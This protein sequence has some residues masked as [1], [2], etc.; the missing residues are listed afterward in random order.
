MSDHRN[1]PQAIADMIA[2]FGIVDLDPCSNAT[3]VIN[4]RFRI[5]DGVSGLESSWRGLVYVN[6]PWSNLLPWVRKAAEEAEQGAEILFLARTESATAWA[7]L[8]CETRDAHVDLRKRYSFPT[9]GQPPTTDTRPTTISY[10]GRRPRHFRDV[11]SKYGFVY[12]L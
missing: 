12:V 8:L 3:S 11:F 2:E 6:G 7:H 4:A 1:T 9:E 5:C 10:F